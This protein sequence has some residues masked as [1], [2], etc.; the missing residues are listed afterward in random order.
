MKVY[1]ERADWANEIIAWLSTY[2]S[3]PIGLSE[4]WIK[5]LNDVARKICV[6]VIFLSLLFGLLIEQI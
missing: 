2:K 6:P 3:F 4:H 5:A 1:S